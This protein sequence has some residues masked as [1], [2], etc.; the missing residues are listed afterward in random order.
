MA[1]D[2]TK[3]VDMASVVTAVATVAGWLPKIAALF[4]IIWLGM[5]M[6]IHWDLFVSKIAKTWGKFRGR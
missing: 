2:H 4:S 1:A 5:Q 3:Y 6:V